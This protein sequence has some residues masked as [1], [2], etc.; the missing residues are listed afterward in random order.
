[1]IAA[2]ISRVRLRGPARL[3][4]FQGDLVASII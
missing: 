4:R 3:G 2:I 1:M